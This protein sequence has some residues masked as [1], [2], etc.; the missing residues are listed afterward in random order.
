MLPNCALENVWFEIIGKSNKNISE[1]VHFGNVV[2]L[3]L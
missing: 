2:Y 3:T 1:K